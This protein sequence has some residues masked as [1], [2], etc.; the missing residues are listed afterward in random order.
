MPGQAAMTVSV[1]EVS[2]ESSKE[3][4]VV[5]PRIAHPL[6]GR[7]VANEQVGSMPVEVRT[8]C[9]GDGR[10]LTQSESIGKQIDFLFLPG[11]EGPARSRMEFVGVFLQDRRRVMVWIDADRVEEDVLADSRA[12]KLL[13]L[14]QAS[15]L[16]R[17]GKLTLGVDEVDG[18]NPVLDQVVVKP[19]APAVLS[20]EDHIWKVVR[21]KP[22]SVRRASVPDYRRDNDKD[23]RPDRHIRFHNAPGRMSSGDSK[24][25]P[26]G[27][28]IGVGSGRMNGVP[29]SSI[30]HRRSIALSSCIVLW[31]CS[32]NIPLQSRNRSA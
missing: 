5:S 16:E 31:Q 8:R 28:T 27:E 15:G 32:M 17:A 3:T 2:N 13:H 12:Q 14:R 1:N 10:V 22:A 23:D 11:E 6:T 30:S 7:F 20:G 18:D 29:G 25:T 19:N 9:V 24:V 26:V 21:T 4:G